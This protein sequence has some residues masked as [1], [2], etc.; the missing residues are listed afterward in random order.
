VAFA[1]A[2]RH[3]H[4]RLDQNEVVC[5]FIRRPSSS[6][7]PFL[8]RKKGKSFH[9]LASTNLPFPSFLKISSLLKGFV[10]VVVVFFAFIFIIFCF[11]STECA[12]KRLMICI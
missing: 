7:F 10:A 11:E 9:L 6:V 1:Y 4:T 3:L 12:T 5:N 2:N 8:L